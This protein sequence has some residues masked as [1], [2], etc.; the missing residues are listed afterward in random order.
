[1][2]GK[3]RDLS[4]PWPFA[5]SAV[6][7]N[8]DTGL[9]KLVAMLTML[10]D[11]AGK[12]LF[13]QYGVMR[14]IGRIAFPIYAYCLAAGCVY[15]RNP[16]NYLRRIV[17]LA[18]ISQ[19]LYA[20]ALDHEVAAM[21]SVS[22]AER[23]VRAVLTFY[24]NSWAKPSI[25]FTL[26]LGLLLI[27]SLRERQLV[28]TVAM[29]VFCWLIQK[30]ID[31]GFRCIFLILLFYV[32]C[33]QRWLSLPCVLAFMVWWGLQ[34]SGYELFGVRFGLQM[35]AV[36]ALPL[37]YIHTNTHL[38]LPKWLFYAFY[39]AHLAAIYLICRFAPL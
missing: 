7:L 19:P 38:R 23:P 11:H 9:L 4:I 6:K 5:P 13:P 25:L 2:A 29:L 22:F 8:D 33:A 35:F 20:I 28:F 10:C 32:F 18:L 17:A 37:I 26:A 12:M 24:I 16:L 27:W 31:Y 39:P 3:K 14:I 21:Y 34:G 30:K 1:M 15:T 36:C